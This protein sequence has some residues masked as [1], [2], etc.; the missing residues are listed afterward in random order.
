MLRV[1]AFLHL[2]ADDPKART[3]LHRLAGILHAS[4]KGEFAIAGIKVGQAASCNAGDTLVEDGCGPQV[5]ATAQQHATVQ[6]PP[7][8]RRRKKN[9][10]R[11]LKER[12]QMD[13][14]KAKEREQQREAAQRQHEAA[15]PPLPPP[16]PKAE[17]ARK[18]G[19]SKAKAAP[20]PK[21]P[22]ASALPPFK[23]VESKLDLTYPHA[24]TGVPSEMHRDAVASEF[25]SVA[26]QFGEDVSWMVKESEAYVEESVATASSKADG[27]SK[28]LAQCDAGA[29]AA[30]RY[31]LRIEWLQQFKE[32]TLRRIAGGGGFMELDASGDGPSS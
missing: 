7:A 24:L 19:K 27:A 10:A 2:L 5:V 17:P 6:A 1:T 23:V 8:R 15:F 25:I 28:P 9:E 32:K 20:E 26:N 4:G 21:P 29:S 3:G 30:W 16:A 14:K 13:V 12:I 11:R 22:P 31:S 18:K